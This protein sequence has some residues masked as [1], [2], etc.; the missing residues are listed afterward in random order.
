MLFQFFNQVFDFQCGNRIERGRRFIH[1]NDFGIDRNRAGDANTLLLPAGK[2]E[3]AFMQTVTDFVPNRR[4][5]QASFHRFIQ[6]RFLFDPHR[7]QRKRDV[8]INAHRERVRLLE[9]H[10]DL[11]A[12]LID[13]MYIK[14][15][16]SAI[17][18][19]AGDPTAFNQIIHPVKHA[20]ECR[21]A[22][23][24]RSDQR[25]DRAFFNLHIDIKERLFFPII[26]V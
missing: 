4:L 7:F 16:L 14:Y 22:A 5:F 9:Y 2:S 23:P 26:E 12:Q 18:Y 20:Q 10:P 21:L 8:I 15:I 3:R 19:F 11:P 17:Q 24:R 6:N 13:I 1:E 25:G